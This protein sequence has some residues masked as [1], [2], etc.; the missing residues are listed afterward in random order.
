VVRGLS[1][2]LGAYGA[3]LAWLLL[4]PS[5]SGPPEADGAALASGAVGLLLL[6]ACVLVLLP[7]R[8]STFT[9]AMLVLSGGLL[10]SA[11]V[12]AQATEGAEL[13]KAMF[14][15]AV[16]MLGGRWLGTGTVLVAVPL[17][18]TGLGL[19]SILTSPDAAVILEPPGGR[20]VFAVTVPLWEARPGQVALAD[21]VF[22]AFFASLRHLPGLRPRATVVGLVLA[23]VLALAAETLLDQAVPVTLAL[24]GSV[25]AVNLDRL[26]AVLAH[27]RSA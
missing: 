24:A 19:A 27:D 23:P 8:R 12:Q 25:L 20:D 18:L 14:A 6:A 2:L 9:L 5:A 22:L 1:A 21:L 13:A 7:A 11:L 16:G 3:T 26:P 4:A 17:L 15:A 10:L